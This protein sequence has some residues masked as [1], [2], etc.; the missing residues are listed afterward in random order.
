[1]LASLPSQK[2]NILSGK[3]PR[4]RKKYKF[5]IFFYFCLPA[6]GEEPEG[7]GMDSRV[8]KNDGGRGMEEEI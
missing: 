3:L 6:A 8:R 2:K 1:M 7:T 4:A 5:M